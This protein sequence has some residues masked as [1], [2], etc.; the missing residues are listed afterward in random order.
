[1]KH[2]GSMTKCIEEFGCAGRHKS[3]IFHY[4]QSRPEMG[5]DPKFNA[6]R[7]EPASKAA[8]AEGLDID[9]M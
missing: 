4:L 7:A 5:A 3:I 6:N 2:F 9:K 8:F 1:M